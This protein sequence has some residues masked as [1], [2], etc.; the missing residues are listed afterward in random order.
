MPFSANIPQLKFDLTSAYFWRI[1]FILNEIKLQHVVQHHIHTNDVNLDP[2]INMEYYIRLTPTHPLLY[3]HM[4]Q[5]IYFFFLLALFGA[6]K[7]I[8]SISKW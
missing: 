6:Q 7:I 8:T 2:D 4:F 3:H 1:V 5:Y